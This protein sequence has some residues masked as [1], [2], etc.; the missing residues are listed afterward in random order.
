LALTNAG[1]AGADTHNGF[2]GRNHGL[3][4]R[5][6]YELAASR[7]GPTGQRLDR[8][9]IQVRVRQSASGRLFALNEVLQPALWVDLYA[10][11]IEVVVLIIVAH[12]WR[13]DS[14]L[15]TGNLRSGKALNRGVWFGGPVGDEIM[16]VST[17]RSEDN[18]VVSL[19]IS[20]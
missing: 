8:V 1:P 20:H 12:L 14:V 16:K 15:D 5:K 2:G 11:R 18:D 17:R 13:K 7:V 10:F 3:K 4:G 19:A 9:V 6:L